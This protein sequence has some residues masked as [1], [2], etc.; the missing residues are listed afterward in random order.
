LHKRNSTNYLKEKSK[1]KKKRILIWSA[2]TG[3][4][5][6]GLIGAVLSGV[7]PTPYALGRGGPPQN[8]MVIDGATRDQ[9]IEAAISK[10]T[11][12]YIFP[13]KAVEIVKQLRSE[14]ARGDFANVTSAEKLA[15]KLTDSLQK[16][17]K[18][19]HL[20]IR[21]FEEAIVEE[22]PNQ[23][24]ASAGT[25]KEKFDFMR[26]NFGFEKVDRLQCNIGYIDLRT[27][28]PPEMDAERI[29]AAMSLLSETW[30][31][32]IDLRKNGGGTPEGV[33]L[34]SSYF[35][36]E[37]TH[38]NDIYEL[39]TNKIEERWTTEKVAGKKYGT[40]RKIYILTSEDTFSAAED[41]AYTMKNTKRATLVG[42]TTGGGANAGNR[43][44]LNAHFMMN[45]PDA[46]PISPI[47]KTNWEGVGITPDIAVST[48]KSLDVARMEILKDLLANNPDVRV[49]N[50]VKRCIA[51]M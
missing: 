6:L 34:I 50:V 12:R 2:V 42:E 19:K 5:L 24:Q 48:K 49:K 28:V 51:D 18:D 35:F 25:D 17:S 47:T 16:S 39:E 29:T 43:H 11:Q 4:V 8:D 22:T 10:L 9:V 33:A 21:Y 36:D 31:L 23:N 13:E 20:E 14:I 38:L 30:A 32:I 46:R 37:R 27:F 41:F 45:V 40:A 3:T 7:I 44:R 26:K 1:M 15:N